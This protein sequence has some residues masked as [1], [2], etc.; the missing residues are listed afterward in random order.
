M[1]ARASVLEE[2]NVPSVNGVRSQEVAS[3]ESPERL[4]E[5]DDILSHAL[6][7]FR[8]I[9]GR[10]LRNPEDAEDAVQ[11]AMLLA[12]RHIARFDGRSQMLTWVTRIVIN[13]ARMRVRWLSRRQT[14]SL[15][16]SPGDGQQTIA[17]MLADP[18]PTPEQT[19]G[20]RQLRELVGTLTDSLPPSQR[21]AMQLLQRDDFS[22][23]QAAERLG[24]AQ[25]T[26]KARLARGRAELTERLQRA[27][28][29]LKSQTSSSRSRAWYKASASGR[30]RDGAGSLAHLPQLAAVPGGCSWAGA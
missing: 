13:A 24:V 10:W 29:A 6:P 25:G 3:K 18:R 15:D 17:E 4:R 2:S 11:D 22:I 27:T 12:F 9:A 1:L 16:Q 28:S 8:R 5:F 7:R 21:A 20:Q 26:V 19:L 23:R 14:L 30:R